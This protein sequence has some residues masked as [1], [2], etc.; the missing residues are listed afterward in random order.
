MRL[1]RLSYRG[2]LNGA[3]AAQILPD[4]HWGVFNNKPFWGGINFWIVGSSR[5]GGIIRNNYGLMVIVAAPVNGGW[6]SWLR[7]FGTSHGMCGCIRTVFCTICPQH[8]QRFLR[9]GWM[10]RLYSCTK[11]GLS[12]CHGQHWHWCKNCRKVYCSCNWWQNNNGLNWLRW[13]SKEKLN[14]NMASISGTKV[15]HG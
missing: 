10:I 3:M 5:V 15:Y 11:L 13:Q 12:F 8:S 4:W 2:S 6:Q 7:N 14:M 1:P 9:K